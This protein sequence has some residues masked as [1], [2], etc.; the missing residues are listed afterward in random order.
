VLAGIFTRRLDGNGATRRT[1]LGGSYVE[2]LA[3]TIPVD[4][5]AEAVAEHLA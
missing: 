5:T 2:L 3:A 1:T 4:A